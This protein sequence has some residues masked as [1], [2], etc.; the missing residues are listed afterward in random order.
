MEREGEREGGR[1]GKGERWREVAKEGG[2]EGE[3]ETKYE[4]KKGRELR[5]D[6]SSPR[7]ANAGFQPQAL[8]PSSILIPPRFCVEQIWK[9]KKVLSQI[10]ESSLEK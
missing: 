4:Y 5:H 8:I 6:L 7:S 3:G 1:R 9:E 10:L 2:R